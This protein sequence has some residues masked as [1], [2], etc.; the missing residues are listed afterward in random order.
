MN[1]ELREEIFECKLYITDLETGKKSNEISI[2]D[3]IF[4]DNL[5]FEF[6]S[7]EDED[8]GQL[9]YKDFKFFIN[10][11]SVT[12]YSPQYKKALEKLNA[13]KFYIEQSDIANML[14]GKEILKIIG[15]NDE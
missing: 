3:L 15:G 11:Y 1:N 9:P 10:D 2:T 7:Y 13:I 12:F 8:Y 5:E 14:W 4:D 6:G